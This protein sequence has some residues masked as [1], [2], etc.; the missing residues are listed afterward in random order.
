MQTTY[1]TTTAAPTSYDSQSIRGTL[2]PVDLARS[3]RV[4]LSRFTCVECGATKNEGFAHHPSWCHTPGEFVRETTGPLS[5][6]E[7]PG[8]FARINAHEEKLAA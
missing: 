1:D 4:G 2:E 7:A 5:K 3:R 8:A 6:T